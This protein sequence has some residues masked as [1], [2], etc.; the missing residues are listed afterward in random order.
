ME[1]SKIDRLL[2]QSVKGINDTVK[3]LFSYQKKEITSIRSHRPM[4]LVV[5]KLI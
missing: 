1:Q 3:A 4:T 2:K 5:N